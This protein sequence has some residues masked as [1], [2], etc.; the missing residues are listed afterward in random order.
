MHSYRAKTYWYTI[1][2][3]KVGMFLLLL[4]MYLYVVCTF[5]ENIWIWDWNFRFL[6]RL[7]WNR[8]EY[9]TSIR[10]SYLNRNQLLIVYCLLQSNF[11]KSN[12]IVSACPKV[13][14]GICPLNEGLLDE[15]T[16]SLTKVGSIFWEWHVPC[17]PNPSFVDIDK[18]GLIV[19]STKYLMSYPY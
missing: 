13:E 17:A 2:F 16:E 15:N 19:A 14:G 9:G 7:C 11:S 18:G 5:L 12:D 4:D 6:K 8:M 3:R 1:Y 10:I